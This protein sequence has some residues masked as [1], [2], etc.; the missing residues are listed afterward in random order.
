[1]HL[2]PTSNQSR[3][4]DEI[5]LVRVLFLFVRKWHWFLAGLVVAFACAFVYTRYFKQQSYAINT[6]ILITDDSKDLDLGAVFGNSMADFR[7]SPVALE[8]EIELLKSYTLARRVFEK[9]NWRVS[10]YRKEFFMLKGLYPN[11]PFLVQEETDAPNPEGLTLSM[12]PA[13]DNAYF[14]SADGEAMVNDIPVSIRFKATGEFGKP[15]QN[16]YFHFTLYNKG[17]TPPEKGR[18]YCFHFNQV[19]TLTRAYLK[20]QQIEPV[21]RQS[22]V[23][24]LSTKGV[25]P[26]R[27]THYLNGLIG[28]YIDQHVDF[29]TAA[30]RRSLEFI[31]KRLDGISD[32]LTAAGTAVTR[33]RSQNRVLDIS[34]KGG[35]VMQQLGEIEQDRSKSQMQ[36]DY[37]SNLLRYLEN[38]DSIRH[39]LM[40]SVVGVQD[41]SLNAFVLKL[42]ELYSR[43]A[44]LAF[45]TY[46]GNPASQLIDNE[47]N[48]VTGQLR[49]SLVNLISNARLSVQALQRREA[50]IDRQMNNLPAKEQQLISVTRQYELTN[51]IYTYLLQKQAET[52]I[53]LASTVPN[54]QV[55]D[56][57][58]IERIEEAGTSDNMLYLM[59]FLAGVALPGVVILTLE[60]LNNTIHLQEDVEK[61]SPLTIIGNV[62]HSASSTELVVAENPQAPI[63]EAY[64][65]IRTNLQY[66][67][68]ENG[69]KVIG[70]HSI[71]PGEGK[72]FSS[73]NL[74]CI[75]ALNSKKTLIIGSDMRKPRLHEIADRKNEAGLSTFLIG[76]ST[77]EEVVQS[78][79][80]ENLWFLPAGPVPPNPS[81]LLERDLFHTLMERAREEFDYIVIDNAPVSMV[82]DGLITA[83]E[84]DLNIFILRYGV[85][86]KDQLTFINDVAAKKI[87]SHGICIVHKFI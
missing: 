55:I 43:R 70:I 54:V 2:T 14:L 67:L 35:L 69:Q 75:L 16:E 86:R 78:T 68:S 32:S 47:I 34:A 66:M 77:Y 57:A 13:G 25:E 71:R 20:K 60:T 9:L 23:I 74:A 76:R 22:Q 1:M 61:L 45:S 58:R 59:A 64:R 79:Q 42:S 48:Q 50:D 28:E 36:L 11:E 46:A 31:N 21:G 65:S 4:D 12:Q 5:D 19:N 44:V 7:Y 81:E 24:R 26:L 49:E 80:V 10:W 33:F 37:F 30:K 41:P 27:E 56:P 85:S 62:P 15:F 6:S 8:N 83:R 53:A 39:V 38:S 17:A 3:P 84:T 73:I 40:P 63:T 51:D 82:T 18:E 29:R 72:S 52:D 87:M